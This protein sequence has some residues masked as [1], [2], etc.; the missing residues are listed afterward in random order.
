MY[1][2]AGRLP[3]LV[4]TLPGQWHEGKDA[5]AQ[6]NHGSNAFASFCSTAGPGSGRRTL[7]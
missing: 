4:R 2:L 1:A 3:P 7:A 6:R 5:A